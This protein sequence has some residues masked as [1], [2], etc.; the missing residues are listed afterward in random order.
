MRRKPRSDWSAGRVTWELSSQTKP[1]RRTGAYA[2]KV[3]AKMPAHWVGN[4]KRS[5]GGWRRGFK[6]FL[7]LRGE[8]FG[9]HVFQRHVLDRAVGG[10]AGLENLLGDLDD[11]FARHPQRELPVGVD[12]LAEAGLPSVGK[13]MGLLRRNE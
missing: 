10:E 4:A 13:R 2:A 11:V 7:R 8:Q 5:N 6:A 9:D 3:R 12:G 1:A